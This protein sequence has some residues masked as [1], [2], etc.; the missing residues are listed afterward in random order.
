MATRRQSRAVSRLWVR[1]RKCMRLCGRR[2]QRPCTIR[3]RRRG[4]GRGPA[5]RRGCV[6]RR[7]LRPGRRTQPL[8]LRVATCWIRRA[9]L[10]RG[11]G[12][13]VPRARGNRPARVA[14]TTYT[15]GGDAGNAVRRLR[16]GAAGVL[17]VV[18]VPD[19]ESLAP[20]VRPAAPG[21]SAPPRPGAL[22]GGGVPTA[23]GAP[24]LR[25]GRRSGRHD[26]APD[27]RGDDA[28]T[29]R[30][31]GGAPHPTRPKQREGKGTTGGTATGG[32]DAGDNSRYVGRPRRGQC[33]P[34]CP[35]GH[36]ALGK[37]RRA[38]GL[39]RA[40]PTLPCAL[41]GRSTRHQAAP[42]LEH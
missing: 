25:P 3:R 27:G 22:S 2:R 38:D 34:R 18:L 33:K 11:Q 16:L 7:P 36:D 32:D 15:R 28:S 9:R 13:A 6:Q 37:L 5:L 4:S 24:A 29:L 20:P 10:L 26:G 39:R 17:G 40:V 1:A 23:A 31:G 21:D 35:A 12:R 30:V 19:G 41:E 8:R 14:A 42:P